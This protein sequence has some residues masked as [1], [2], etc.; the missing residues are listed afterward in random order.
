MID[1]QEDIIK[2]KK[3]LAAGGLQKPSSFVY[4]ESCVQLAKS[5]HTDLV[6][7]CDNTIDYASSGI[8]E[9]PSQ[10]TYICN[11]CVEAK[12]SATSCIEYL[13]IAA[14][15]DD[16]IQVALGYDINCK[17]SGTTPSAAPFTYPITEFEPL[18]K[19]IDALL[20]IKN[21]TPDIVTLMHE[22]NTALTPP[23]EPPDSSI[24]S[25]KPILSDEL[26]QDAISMENK[27]RP[28]QGLIKLTSD[29]IKSWI[30]LASSDRNANL[31]SFTNAIQY[32]ILDANHKNIAISD[33]ISSISP[34]EL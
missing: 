2:F 18:R 31:T 12:V 27:L 4:A 10:I 29:R 30:D 19:C 13:D 24:P 33:A 26:K 16:L 6:L 21:I 9:L 15:P 5:I 14:K 22:I 28:I 20:Q 7:T 23:P 17:L 11:E 34:I 32:T 25:D 8:H 1:S 3:Y